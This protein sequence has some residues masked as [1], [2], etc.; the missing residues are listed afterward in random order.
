M[1]KVLCM[2]IALT[3]LMTSSCLS[4]SSTPCTMTLAI[5]N[6]SDK[7]LAVS[8]KNDRT[9]KQTEVPSGKTVSVDMASFGGFLL[10]LVQQDAYSVLYQID[11][12]DHW[13]PETHRIV[14]TF[15]RGK[16]SI[17]DPRMNIHIADKDAAAAYAAF[18]KK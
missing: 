1:K 3:T 2:F 17:N 4:L 7:P 5:E 18:Y 11:E 13:F 9:E 10:L 12:R 15:D 14:I 6:N 16:A 8:V